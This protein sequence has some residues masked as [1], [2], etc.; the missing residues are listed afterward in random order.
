MNITLRRAHKL[1]QQLKGLVNSK[2]FV[3]S[4]EVSIFDDNPTATVEQ[5]RQRSL[6]GAEEAI[7][8][9]HLRA[10]IRR[11]VQLVHQEQ[12]IDQIITDRQVIVD[13]IKL[14]NAMLERRS[15]RSAVAPEVS[16]AEHE[17]RRGEKTTSRYN[18]SV[19]FTVMT[20][21]YFEQIETELSDAQRTLRELDDKLLNA[22]NVNH[23]EL[24]E[25]EVAFLESVNLI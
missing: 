20:G 19:T 12:D 16:L 5:E 8:A 9:L 21:E 3:D 7:T 14:R 22:N 2:K 13:V 4:I 17:A 15:H 6:N 10:N 24:Q 11:R 18:D 23:I 25:D 1:Q